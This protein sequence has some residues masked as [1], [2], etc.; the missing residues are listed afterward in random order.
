[1]FFVLIFDTAYWHSGYGVLES[2]LS[3][4]KYAVSSLL[5]DDT[6]VSILGVERPWLSEAKGFIFPNNDT[7][8]ILPAESQRDTTD[9]PVAVTDSSAIDY[10]SANESSVCST[11]IPPLEKLDG[12]EL[13]SGPKTIKLILKSKSTFKAEALKGAII[14]HFSFKS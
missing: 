1:M 11:L 14:K 12:V 9:P 8:R 13:V 5:A 7:G 10:D 3:R 4:R 2:P 6:K